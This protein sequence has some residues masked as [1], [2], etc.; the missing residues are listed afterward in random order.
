MIKPYAMKSVA[1]EILHH[2]IK[3]GFTI[4]RMETRPL[5]RKE[6][7]S[8]Y[9]EHK[10]KDFFSDLCDYI[11]SGPLIIMQL[12]KSKTPVWVEWRHEMGETDPYDADEY[13]IRKKWGKGRRH[14]AVHGSDSGESAKLECEIFWTT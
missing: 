13:T 10:D 14:N 5:T 4:R 8:I 6:S 12:Q 1:A 11:C 7:E 2:I 9:E 3:K